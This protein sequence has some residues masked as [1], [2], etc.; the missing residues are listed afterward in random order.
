MPAV[1]NAAN[2]AAVALFLNG[3]IGFT[4]IPKLIEKAMGAYTVKYDYSLEDVL[5]ADSF[6]REYVFGLN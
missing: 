2:E 6:A 3:K 4:D 5:E 1:L